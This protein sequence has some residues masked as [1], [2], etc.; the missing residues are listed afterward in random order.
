MHTQCDILLLSND[1]HIFGKI[2]IESRESRLARSSFKQGIAARI[3]FTASMGEFENRLRVCKAGASGNLIRIV[4]ENAIGDTINSRIYI[5]L[6]ERCRIF[7]GIQTKPHFI[8]SI[9]EHI[10]SCICLEDGQTS[11]QAVLGCNSHS[12]YI[13][14]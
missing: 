12:K 8:L 3:V 5:S 4:N 7:S 14:Y 10:A 9:S 6:E 1:E 13:A 11:G 2:Q